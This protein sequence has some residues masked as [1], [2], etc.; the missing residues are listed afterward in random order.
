M[1]LVNCHDCGKPIS[2][3]ALI[4]PQCGVKPKKKTSIVTW[5]IGGIVLVVVFRTC[6]V[7]NERAVP[8]DTAAAVSS[9]T[10][11]PSCDAANFIVKNIKSRR[12]YDHAIFTAT[13]TNTGPTACGVQLKAS[14]YDKAGAVVN[15]SDFWPASVRNIEPGANEN[16]QSFLRF[17]P[18]VKTVEIVP[19]S[20]R[21]WVA[22]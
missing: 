21:V 4:C 8:S 16:F 1:A 14:T 17:D 13:V 5:V 10:I 7:M 22:R 20:A 3:N 2:R 12:E 19:I 11:K 15:T 18:A 6:T 9:L